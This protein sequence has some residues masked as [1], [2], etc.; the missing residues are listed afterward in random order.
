MDV[1]RDVVKKQRNSKRKGPVGQHELTPKHEAPSS[2]SCSSEPSCAPLPPP[3]LDE[4]PVAKHGGGGDLQAA[5]RSAGQA[6]F[7]LLSSS[8]LSQAPDL[9]ETQ[10]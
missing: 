1:A 10:R 2:E 8:R 7:L 5:W 4:E 6:S 3:L 9:L